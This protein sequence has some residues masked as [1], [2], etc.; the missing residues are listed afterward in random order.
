MLKG[1]VGREERLILNGNETL[2][3]EERKKN[4]VRKIIY[5]QKVKQARLEKTRTVQMPPNAGKS[6]L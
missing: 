1:N 4:A 3:K 6:S 5:R 2:L